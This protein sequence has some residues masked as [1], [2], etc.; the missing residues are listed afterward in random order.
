L[1][2][3]YADTSVLFSL[4]APDA[5]SGRADAWR[6]AN[7]AALPFTAFHRL[8][9]RNALSLAIF[10]RRLTTA[11]CQAVWAEVENDIAAG[12]L[13]QTGGLSHYVLVD[14]T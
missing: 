4:Y 14:M 10:Q 6:L 3:S 11:E 2:K 9:L 12:L 7:P 13:V 5:N 8:E 1:V